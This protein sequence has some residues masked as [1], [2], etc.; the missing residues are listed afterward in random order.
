MCVDPKFS[1]YYVVL[2]VTEA[3]SK[4]LSMEKQLESRRGAAELNEARAQ[5]SQKLTLG[6][7]RQNYLKSR[8]CFSVFSR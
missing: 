7:T 1:L 6:M 8:K 3:P 2:C 5:Q 4:L